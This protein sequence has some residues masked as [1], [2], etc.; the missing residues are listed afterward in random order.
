MI[1]DH[2]NSGVTEYLLTKY[3]MTEINIV[4]KALEASVKETDNIEALEND[5]FFY[6]EDSFGF[7]Y[8]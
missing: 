6:S 2:I 7:E 5:I 3:P 4:N 1:D 8:R